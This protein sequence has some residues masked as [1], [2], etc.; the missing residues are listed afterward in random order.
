MVTFVDLFAGIGGFHLGIVQA[1]KKNGLDAQ[2]TLAVDINERAQK[3]YRKNFAGTNILN[4][5]TDEEV[6]ESIPTDI[7]IVCGGFPCQPFSQ[8]GKKMGTEDHRGTLFMHIAEILDKKKPKAVF[9]ENVRNLR[10]IKNPDGSSTLQRIKDELKRAGYD[11]REE[12][13]RAKDFG[14]PTH[15]PRIYLV[16]FRKDVLADSDL[17]RWPTITHEA[18]VTLAKYFRGLPSDWNGLVAK[19]GWPDQVGNTLR[20]GGLGSGF[21]T[22]DGV[23][24]R[25][26]RNWDSYMFYED[27]QHPKQHALTVNEAKAMMGFPSH[28]EFPEE[29][30]R[31]QS[32]RQLGNSVAVPVIAAI[33][34]QIIKTIHDG[35]DNS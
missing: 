19:N 12:I 31:A 7:D 22:E 5:V 30:T 32:L 28:F 17:F 18:H 9:L 13:F 26:R 6:K 25:D 27:S 16:G 20:V 14:L 4:D 10:N 3:T 29:L 21:R 35:S 1:A 15:R 11:V 33:A 8:A 24:W 23:T 34:E 2:C